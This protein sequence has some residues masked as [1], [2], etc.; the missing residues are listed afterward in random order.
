MSRTKRFLGGVSLGYTNQGLV[1]IAGLWL[2]PF[3]LHRIG[4]HDYGLWLVG[5]QILA[6]LSLMDFGIVALLPR[7]TAYATGRTGVSLTA[8]GLPEIIGQTAVL[9]LCQTPLVAL[10]AFILWLTM[11]AHWGALRMPIGIVMLSFVVTFPLRIFPAILQGLQDLAALGK[12]NI[13]AWLLGTAIS[14]TLVLVGLSL[15]ALAVGWVVTQLTISGVSYLRLRR[16]FPEILPNRLHSLSWATARDQ[17][18]KG[19]WVSL[20]QIA[21]VLMGGTDILIIGKLFG[22]ASVVPFVITG[23]LIGVLSNQPHM[24]MTA[25]GPA[26][27]QMRMGESRE[28]LREVCVALSQAMLMLSG[29]VVCVVLAVNQGFVG[30]WVGA[31]QYGGFWLT[32]LI[33]LSMLLRHWN[34]TVGYALYCFGYERRICITALL[35]GLVS[36]GAVFLFVRLFGLVGAPLGMILGACLIGLPANLSA[37][38]SESNSSVWGLVRPLLPWFVR[39]VFLASLI[40][41]VARIWVPATLGLIALTAIV[42]ALAY[43]VLMFPLALRAPLGQYVRPRLIPLRIKFLRFLRI[44]SFVEPTP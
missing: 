13:A 36:V 28:R 22:P 42:A 3:L 6:Y 10:A 35:D 41:A 14:I 40:G 17:L 1:M 27:S 23:K 8:K 43:G 37:L 5:V 19:S 24:L 2:T 38:A 9:V 12:L 34:L 39:F 33:L 26:L 21:Q 32:V 25:A 4:Q 15:Y 11:S 18:G 16:H 31:G 20:A 30:R 44:G 7:A 29:A